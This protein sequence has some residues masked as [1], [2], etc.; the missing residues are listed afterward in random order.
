MA[1]H[2]RNGA[3]ASESKDTPAPSPATK[4]QFSSGYSAS[5]SGVEFYGWNGADLVICVV[6]ADALAAWFGVTVTE[7]AAMAQAY[8]AHREQI[9]ERAARKHAAGAFDRGGRIFLYVSDG[10]EGGSGD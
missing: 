10:P 5:R 9:H 7:E 1:R 6:T 3:P 2:V 8:I 4:L